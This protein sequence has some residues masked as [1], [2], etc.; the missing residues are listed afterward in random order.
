MRLTVFGATGRTG[1]PLVSQALSAGHDVIAFT[2]SP[3]KLDAS[4][5]NLTVVVGD[6]YTGE[7]VR[8]A[9]EGADAVASVLGQTSEGPD[10]LLTVAGGHILDAMEGTNLTRFVTLV[11]AGVRTES[12]TVSLGGT[13]MGAVLKLFA[14]HILEDARSHVADV[15]SRDLDWTI[16]RAPR[17]RDGPPTDDYRHGDLSLGIRDDIARADVADF[18]LTVLEEGSYTRELPLVSA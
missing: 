2:R 17:L 1:E 6:A 4:D 10:D 18:V 11:G 13:V 9:I 12:D 15:R 16:V 7:G 5:D 3:D 8:E 14:G